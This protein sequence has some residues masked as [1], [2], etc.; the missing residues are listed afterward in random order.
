MSFFYFQVI[1]IQP[2]Y[3]FGIVSII[4]NFLQTIAIIRDVDLKW[5]DELRN[6]LEKFSLAILNIEFLSPECFIADGT[7]NYSYKLKIILLLPLALFCLIFV[8]VL[9]WNARHK[10]SQRFPACFGRSTKAVGL[11]KRDSPYIILF[12]NFNGFI[13]FVYMTV[14]SYSLA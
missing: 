6:I 9:I 5:P 14:A 8:T 11:V 13:P 1:I 12:R 3:S 7:L 10:L 2:F 4:L